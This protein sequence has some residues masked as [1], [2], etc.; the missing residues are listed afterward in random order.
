MVKNEWIVVCDAG[1]IIHLDELNCL[2]ILDFQKILV[3]ITV[4]EE[5]LQYRR[6]PLEKIKGLEIIERTDFTTEFL[7]ICKLYDLHKG[8]A[9]A[10]FLSLEL[11]NSILFTDDGAARLYAKS[12][13]IA[14]HGT[15][16]ILL[17]AVRK[18]IRSP[19]NIIEILKNIKTNS[20]L[21]ISG[22]LIE[23][24]ILAIR[25]IRA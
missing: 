25:Q 19:D 8:E 23:E 16:G 21:H 1:P 11:K 5:I 20:T 10:I 14:V 2:D 22:T 4:W 17:R 24:A 13:N 9:A 18:N 7:E 6:I 15:I 3:P 12:K